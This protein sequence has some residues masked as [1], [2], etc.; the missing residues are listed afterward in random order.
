[1]SMS[2]YNWAR[3]ARSHRIASRRSISRYASHGTAVAMAASPASTSATTVGVPMAPYLSGR[4]PPGD[5]GPPRS[6]LVA[7]AT[8]R[9]SGIS[10]RPPLSARTATRCTN[11]ASS[12][13]G[14]CTR[15][16]RTAGTRTTVTRGIFAPL[17]PMSRRGF[18]IKGFPLYLSLPPRRKVPVIS[19]TGGGKT[20]SEQTGGEGA[21]LL[22]T[23]CPHARERRLGQ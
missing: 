7:R 4:T 16:G 13:R 9:G 23:G 1:M 14:R 15:P 18:D 3:R 8:R 12:G 11:A 20:R 21:R 19:G 10:H 5:A 2:T 6:Y 17:R 22:I